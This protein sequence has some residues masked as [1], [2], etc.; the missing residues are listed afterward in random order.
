MYDYRIRRPLPRD[1]GA[2]VRLELMLRAGLDGVMG[3][4]WSD[5]RGALVSTGFFTYLLGEPTPGPELENLL[6]AACPWGVIPKSEA[7]RAFLEARG[8]G[9]LTRYKMAPPPEFDRERLAALAA[10]LPEGVV[11]RPVDREL[12]DRGIV[13]PGDLNIGHGFSDC[14]DYL[15][16]GFGFAALDGDRT[17]ALVS[18]YLVYRGEAETDI[19]TAEPWRRRGLAA[20]LCAAF[21]LTCGERGL[22]PSWDAQNPA[23]VGLAE[24]LGFTPDHS[25]TLYVLPR[26]KTD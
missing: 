15:A 10:A 25:Y 16:R 5:N 3:E 9:V 1:F 13:T 2:D 24:K 7:W 20:A 23:S 11:R 18:T 8:A 6:P 19:S 12:L 26:E 17:A 21:I 4:S 22:V 14:E